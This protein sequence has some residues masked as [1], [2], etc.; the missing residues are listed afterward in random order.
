MRLSAIRAGDLVLVSRLGRLFYARVS[1]LE[2][3]GL[4]LEPLD[5][6]ITYRRCRAREVREHFARQGRS[7]GDERVVDERQLTLE[8][9]AMLAGEWNRGP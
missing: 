8:A 9:E 4:G 3:G 5:R 2:P 1:A 6:R 7:A